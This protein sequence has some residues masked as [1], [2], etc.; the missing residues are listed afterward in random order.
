MCRTNLPEQEGRAVGAA[1]L[2]LWRTFAWTPE[3]SPKKGFVLNTDEI[4]IAQD[5]VAERLSKSEAG[6]S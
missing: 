3:G 5:V 1:S 2:A 6:G 4:M